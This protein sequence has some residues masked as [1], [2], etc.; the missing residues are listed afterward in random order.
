M[1]LALMVQNVLNE[2][3]Q[4][5]RLHLHM[6]GVSLLS[7]DDSIFTPLK[8]NALCSSGSATSTNV[9]NLGACLISPIFS[10]RSS[11]EARPLL[12]FYHI[13]ADLLLKCISTHKTKQ[14]S[15]FQSDLF[16]CFTIDVW[17]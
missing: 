4:P 16:N 1:K 6:G 12:G 3:L 2:F 8:L 10:M 15:Q 17:K 9:D 11:M 13:Y 7:T 5:Q 14:P